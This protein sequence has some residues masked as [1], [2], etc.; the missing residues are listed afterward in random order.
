MILAKNYGIQKVK[1]FKDIKDS[2]T[3]NTFYWVNELQIV[4]LTEKFTAQLEVLNGK[5]AG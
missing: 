5:T 2:Y 3:Q 4:E 1:K